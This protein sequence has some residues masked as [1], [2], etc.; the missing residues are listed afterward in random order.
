LFT[1]EAVVAIHE[2]ARGIPR[3][4]SVICDNAL[5]SG[6]ALGKRPISREIV[7]EVCRDFDLSRGRAAGPFDAFES[8]ALEPAIETERETEPEPEQ[9]ENEA[10]DVRPRPLG[11][12]H[13]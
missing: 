1:R 11:R 8:E 5:V 13:G 9:V 7:L 10:E 4:I 3:T 6:M 2:H 12:R